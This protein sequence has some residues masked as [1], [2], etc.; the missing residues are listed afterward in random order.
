MTRA[1]KPFLALVLTA[2]ASLAWAQTE[3]QSTTTPTTQDTTPSAASSPHQRQTTESAAAEA[4]TARESDPAA[5]SSP[6]QQDT[7]RTR[8][9]EGEGEDQ[10]MKECIEQLK[11]KNKGIP[12]YT[13]RKACREHV[14]K[15]GNKSAEG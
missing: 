12:D 13:A 7:T 10:A 1:T 3:T 11:E 14:R 9:A 15:Q 4:T 8:T 6:H 5:S 2:F